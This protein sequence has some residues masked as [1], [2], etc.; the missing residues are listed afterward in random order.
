MTSDFVSSLSHCLPSFDLVLRFQKQIETF[1]PK[2]RAVE[3]DINEM[4]TKGIV[5]GFSKS[6]L[7]LINHVVNRTRPLRASK[8]L[9]AK[10]LDAR[11]VPE[12]ECQE[13]GCSLSLFISNLRVL[14]ATCLEK[15]VKSLAET[16]SFL[17]SSQ[18]WHS[19]CCQARRPWRSKGQTQAKGQCEG[20]GQSRQQKGG[21]G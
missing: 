17:C 6:P 19:Y 13:K 7:G 10:L 1:L 11:A 20:K 15:R 3:S 12:P 9:R 8:D 5:N 4:Y 14:E 18:V 2:L 16:C 21:G